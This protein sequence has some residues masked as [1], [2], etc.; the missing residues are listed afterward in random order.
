MDQSR[1][2]RISS[3]PEFDP[4]EVI[5]IAIQIRE[6]VIIVVVRFVWFKV[7]TIARNR[8][9]LRTNWHRQTELYI[10]HVPFS[11]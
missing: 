6:F 1:G 7:S 2:L 10:T 11:S 8:P 5:W 9:T 3:F 4:F